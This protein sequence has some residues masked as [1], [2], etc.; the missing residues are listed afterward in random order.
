[1]HPE[2]DKLKQQLKLQEKELEQQRLL[3]N[4]KELELTELKEKTYEEISKTGNVY[5]WM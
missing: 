5:F 1:M 3:L 2:F 4:L